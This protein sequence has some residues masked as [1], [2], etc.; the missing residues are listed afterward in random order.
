MLI[1]DEA[2]ADIFEPEFSFSPHLSTL[3]QTADVLVLR[4]FGK[5]FGLAGLRVGFVCS[6]KH[7][8]ESIQEINGPWAIN[9]AALFISE[10]ALQ[11]RSWQTEQLKRLQIQSEVM[12]KLLKAHLPVLRMEA[13]ALFITVFLSDAPTAYQQLC[14]NAVYVRL[15]DENNSLRFGIIERS[16]IEQLT[17]AL[18]LMNLA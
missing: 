8:C 12:Q 4:S 14:E 17:L 1:I 16:K 15:T 10:Q 13:N 18:K 2:F 9:G 6:N 7:W 3:K 5:F 11:D